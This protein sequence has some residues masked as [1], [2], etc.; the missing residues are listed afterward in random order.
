MEFQL[1][2]TVGSRKR[3]GG[4]PGGGSPEGKGKAGKARRPKGEGKLRRNKAR[5]A[6]SMERTKQKKLARLARAA[7]GWTTL[8]ARATRT[9]GSAPRPVE[10]IARPA[11]M[12]P[13]AYSV[14][15]RTIAGRFRGGDVDNWGEWL[16]RLWRDVRAAQST[17][18]G[19]P[20]ERLPSGHPFTKENIARWL[21][22]ARE[23]HVS[24]DAALGAR[25]DVPAKPAAAGVRARGKT[26]VR[27]PAEKPRALDRVRATVDRLLKA[28]VDVAQYEGMNLGHGLTVRVEPGAR[29]RVESKANYWG[30]YAVSLT[31]PTRWYTRVHARGLAV[32]DDRLVLD[33]EPVE[34]RLW[35][36]TYADVVRRDGDKPV[37]GVRH[38]FVARR[39]PGF[40]SLR[41]DADA[42]LAEYASE[43]AA[44]LDVL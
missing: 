9:A 33:A 25:T 14:A 13:A 21:K 11:W 41:P 29:P 20:C 10:P 36:V 30:G 2:M 32:L 7:L 34:G 37:L 12:H 16:A 22:T 35:R 43:L 39:G 38:G 15:C 28:Y 42:N 3:K 23:R 8:K 40:L 5:H 27:V 26:A 18:T 17:A 44:T 24:R 6:R 1:D 19:K 31:V 4:G